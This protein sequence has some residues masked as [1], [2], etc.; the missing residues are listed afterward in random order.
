MDKRITEPYSTI[1]NLAK[2]SIETFKKKVEVR[3]NDL[4]NFFHDENTVNQ[5]LSRGENPVIYQYYEHSQDEV[6]GH[7]NFGV[8][9]INPGKIGNEY[10]LTRGHYHAKEE[11]AEVYVGLKG[12]GIILMQNK[13]GQTVHLPISKGTVVYVPP[14]WAHRT[15]NIRKEA[16]SFFY[17]YPSDAGHNYDTIRKMGFAKLIVEENRKPKVVDNPRFSKKL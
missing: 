7:L 11:A 9:I 4:K 13:E 8:T 15:V 12:K 2:G 17:I 5:I 3:L 6:Y 10:Y 16:L 14:F 1:L